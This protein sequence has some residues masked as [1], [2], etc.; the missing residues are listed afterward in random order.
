MIV[1]KFI[2]SLVRTEVMHKKPYNPVLGEHF[3]CFV[4]NGDNDLTEF[5]S[6]QV[7]HHPPVSAL[8]VQ[9]KK[10]GISIETNISFGVTFGGNKA[11]VVT[12]GPL[13]IKTPSDT[14]EMTKVLI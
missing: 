2:L 8:Y 9:N 1:L 4:D 11:G 7:S 14:Y 5:I 12:S 13:V 3:L 10:R 6:E